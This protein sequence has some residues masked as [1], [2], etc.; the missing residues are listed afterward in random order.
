MSAVYS[1]TDNIVDWHY[2]ITGNPA[3]D[4]EIPGT[5]VGMV[6]NPSVYSLI[7][8]RLASAQSHNGIHVLH[9]QSPVA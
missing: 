4:F 3:K 1:R 2:C 5:H 9:T 8:R 7:A 6:F